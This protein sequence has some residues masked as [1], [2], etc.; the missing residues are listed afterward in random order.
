MPFAINQSGI[1]TSVSDRSITRERNYVRRTNNKN[2][3]GYPTLVDT[4][5]DSVL[6]DG[7]P[8]GYE[9]G[10]NGLEQCPNKTPTD[11]KYTGIR[12]VEESDPLGGMILRSSGRGA[13]V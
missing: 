10:G 7:L 2:R 9:V 1:D 6:Y 3:Y 5:W 4:G 12:I 13:F 11:L 8:E